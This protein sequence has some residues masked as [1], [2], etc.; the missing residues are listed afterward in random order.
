MSTAYLEIFR[1]ASH[2]CSVYNRPRVGTK[3]LTGRNRKWLVVTRT[4]GECWFSNN[5][6]LG[7]EINF[8]LK[9]I[10]GNGNKKTRKERKKKQETIS[11]P[12]FITRGYY[13]FFS[14]SL[15]FFFFFFFSCSYLPD[16][17]FVF[18]LRT[19]AS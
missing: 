18:L 8:F 6:N 17:P 16:Y 7:R 4:W 15:F 14:L 12:P 11:F 9:K 13:Y 10:I 5:D 3:T 2:F 19:R 1:S